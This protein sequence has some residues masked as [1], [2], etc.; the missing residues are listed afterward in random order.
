MNTL[1]GRS[2]EKEV[3]ASAIAALHQGHGRVLLIAG[4]PGIGKSTLAR[5]TADEADKANLQ[6]CWGF[7]WEAGGAPAYWPWIQILRSLGEEDVI[8]DSEELAID[9]H[10]KAARH[11]YRSAFAERMQE[12]EQFCQ[13][14]GV[15]LMPLST[16]DDPVSALQTALG[17]R[18]H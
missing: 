4:E 16:D 13:R 14:Y 15:H 7:A 1:V 12:L 17:R 6:T 3:I 18:T 10:T 9:T 5:V 11:D 2:S 8:A